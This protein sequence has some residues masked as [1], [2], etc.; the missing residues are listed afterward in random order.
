MQWPGHSEDKRAESHLTKQWS[1]CTGFCSRE[2]R[3]APQPILPAG[4]FRW[5]VELGSPLC[6]VVSDLPL[7]PNTTLLCLQTGRCWHF[8]A[9]Y[10]NLLIHLMWNEAFLPSK[11]DAE[12]NAKDTTEVEFH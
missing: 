10:L 8:L 6:T 3:V 1:P 7:L 12:T 11:V 4:P 2:K 9:M 5:G